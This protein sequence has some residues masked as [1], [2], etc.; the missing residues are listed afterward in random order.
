MEQVLE[1]LLAL[2]RTE[3]R[4][5]M[6]TLVGTR[7]TTPKKEGARMW[8]GEGGRVLGSVTIGGCVD[9]KVIAESEAVL[10]GG[11]PRLLSLQLGDEDAWEIGLSCGGTVDVLVEPLDL[12]AS[13]LVALYR[14]AA[15]QIAR[16][17]AACVVRPLEDPAGARLVLEGEPGDAQ[18]ARAMARGQSATLDGVFYDVHAPRPHLVAVGGGHVSMPLCALART[19]GFRTT[20]VDARPRF[21]TRERFPEADEILIGIASEI[22]ARMALVRSTAVVLTVHDY[23]VELPVLRAVLGSEAGY[24]GMLGNPRRGAAVLGML[25]EEGLPEAQLSRV[26][27]PLGLEI[28]AQ[29]AAEIALSA[30]AQIVAVRA[31]KA[32]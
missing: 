31:G 12:A 11:A 3:R 27:V 1:D 4:V 2:A 21:A 22:V 9:A 10:A 18:A 5:A 24:V 30:M 32:A 29:S 19:L 14:S 23:K 13:P 16:G 15:E 25:R 26:H 28:G 6:A 7:G 20:V 8:V 17:R